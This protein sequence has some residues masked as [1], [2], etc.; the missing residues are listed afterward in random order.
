VWV[1]RPCDIAEYCYSLPPGII[2]G[3]TA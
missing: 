3:S 1:T 2:P